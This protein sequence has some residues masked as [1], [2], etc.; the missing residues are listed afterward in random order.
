M[1]II[2]NIH[3]CECYQ[4]GSITHM[5]SKCLW[6]E[7]EDHR[8]CCFCLDSFPEREMVGSYEKPDPNFW[9]CMSCA[10]DNLNDLHKIVDRAIDQFDCKQED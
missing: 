4:R 8:V 9:V 1:P 3:A 7:V 2:H 6:Q 10:W 5:G